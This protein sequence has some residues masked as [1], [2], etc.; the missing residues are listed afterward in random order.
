MFFLWVRMLIHTRVYIKLLTI[1]IYCFTVPVSGSS[2]S[3][4]K[5]ETFPAEQKASGNPWYLAVT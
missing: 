3:K 1:G 4:D 5:E 2:G